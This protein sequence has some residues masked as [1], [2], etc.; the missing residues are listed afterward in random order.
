MFTPEI[1]SQPSVYWFLIG[2]G[3]ALFELMLP[4]LVVVFFGAGAWTVAII[5]LLFPIGLNA[6]LAIFI[7]SSLVYVAALR[8]RL[9]MKM[10]KTVAEAPELL[11]EEYVGKKAVVAEDITPDKIGAVIFNGTIWKA[12]SD[13]TILTGEQVLITDRKNITLIVANPKL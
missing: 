13:E 12:Q 6:E 11:L 1:I 3:L 7:I 9:K 5:C 8:K 4:G 10:N 2:L